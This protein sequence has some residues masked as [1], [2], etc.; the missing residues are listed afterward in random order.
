LLDRSF[1]TYYTVL[2]IFV[3]LLSCSLQ[4]VY[5]L[6]TDCND[7]IIIFVLDLTQNWHLVSSQK[8]E[9]SFVLNLLILCLLDS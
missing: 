1:E 7:T 6:I 2:A 5:I 3:Y 8:R 9:K 4:V